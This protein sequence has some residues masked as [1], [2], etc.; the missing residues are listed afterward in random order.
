MPH[1]AMHHLAAAQD[2]MPTYQNN[3]HTTRCKGVRTCC[4]DATAAT[5]SRATGRW[6]IHTLLLPSLSIASCAALHQPRAGLAK[7]MISDGGTL[8]MPSLQRW[9]QA[10]PLAPAPMPAANHG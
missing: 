7:D 1:A 9:T 3:T 5:S 10:L 6:Q 4:C 2:W 8:A